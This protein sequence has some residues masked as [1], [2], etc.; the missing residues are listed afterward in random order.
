MSIS[1]ILHNRDYLQTFC[2]DRRNPFRF[3]CYQMVY[4]HVFIYK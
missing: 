3:A 4:L 2:I 1:A